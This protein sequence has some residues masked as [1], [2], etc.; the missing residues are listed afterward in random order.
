MESSFPHREWLVKDNI[1]FGLPL[2]P[3]T[4]G[5]AFPLP[6]G[7]LEAPDSTCAPQISPPRGLRRS[8]SRPGGRCLQISVPIW[9]EQ[10]GILSGVLFSSSTLWTRLHPHRTGPSVITRALQSGKDR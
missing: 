1:A 10:L 7:W 8:A 6:V 2:P 4:I 3:E 9:G 5:G